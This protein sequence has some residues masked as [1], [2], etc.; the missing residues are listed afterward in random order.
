MSWDR[1]KTVLI[2]L[3][4][5]INIFLVAYMLMSISE[6]TQIDHSTVVGTVNVLRSNNITVD[7]DIVPTSIPKYDNIDVYNVAMDDEFKTRAGEKLKVNNSNFELFYNYDVSNVNADNIDKT[8]KNILKELAIDTDCIEVAH[9]ENGG[10]LWARARY[11]EDGIALYEPYITFKKADGGF[12]ISGYWFVP[13]EEI[14][15]SSSGDMA[16]ITSIL[17]DFITNADRNADE[18]CIISGIDIGYSVQNYDTGV[19]HMSMS[20]VPAVRIVLDSGEKYYYNART[21]EYLYFTK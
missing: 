20:A 9:S 8:V 2:F 19:A 16:Y 14:K 6:T 21:G 10:V 3:F 13:R 7:E 17:V 18:K 11:V 4:L 12:D 15:K 5:A 1:V